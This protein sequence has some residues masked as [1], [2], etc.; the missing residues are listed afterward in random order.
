MT[1]GNNVIF[2]S[3]A[4]SGD[5]LRILVEHHGRTNYWTSMYPSLEFKG[6]FGNVSLD[7]VPLKNWFACGV[8]LTEASVNSLT[9]SNFEQAPSHI[10][11]ASQPGVYVG[12][13][14]ASTLTDTWFDSTGWGKGQLFVNGFNLGRYWPSKGPQVIQKFFNHLSFVNLH[15]QGMGSTTK[16]VNWVYS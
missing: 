5:T 12:Y 9:N 4:N 6:L 16:N 13:F 3:S 7:G 10:G 2:S 15:T 8:N 14:N 11:A 1:T